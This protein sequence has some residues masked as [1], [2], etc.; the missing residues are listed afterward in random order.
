[1]TIVTVYGLMMNCPVVT[2]NCNFT[3]QLS[4]KRNI[5][6]Q[7]RVFENGFQDDSTFSSR[8]SDNFSY[9]SNFLTHSNISAE[10]ASIQT[11]EVYEMD[12]DEISFNYRG[13]KVLPKNETTATI[14]IWDTI[15]TMKS[16]KLFRILLD[17]GSNACLIKKSA[18]PA[19]IIPRDLANSKSF[20]TLAGKLSTTQM[21]ILQDVRL[22]WKL[23]KIGTYHSNVP[24]SL[25]MKIVNMTSF[26]E[27]IFYPKTG[28]KLD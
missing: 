2:A 18:L 11:L 23:T 9:F 14:A 21:V 22:P 1:M 27:P 7:M 12:S 3:E 19:G 13:P 5:D 8:D 24:S 4:E 6:D 26:L 16:R 20:N 15:G 10:S 28:V 25:T 17:P